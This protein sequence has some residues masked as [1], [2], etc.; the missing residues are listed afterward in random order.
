M[1]EYINCTWVGKYFIEVKKGFWCKLLGTKDEFYTTHNFYIG[2]EEQA[3]QFFSSQEKIDRIVAIKKYS[4]DIE[5]VTFLGVQ[6]TY[7]SIKRH[8]PL[9]ERRQ[10]IAYFA[11]RGTGGFTK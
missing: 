8:Q 9:L 6:Q 1:N 2:T 3:E 4:L 10:A 7:E 11:E 5:K